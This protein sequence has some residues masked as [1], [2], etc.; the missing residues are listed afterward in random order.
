[1]NGDDISLIFGSAYIIIWLLSSCFSLF[2]CA[3][4]VFCNWKIFVKAGEP[5]WKA[6]IPFYNCYVAYDLFLGN[7]LWFLAIFALCIPIVSLFAL[8]VGVM[9]L[10]RMCQCFGKGVGFIILAIFLSPVALA[11]LA[12]DKSE[13]NPAAA[14]FF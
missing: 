8:F 10:I 3:F 9:Y 12:F 4:V 5:G 1:M 11:I 14:R 2:V 6:I 7:G 13:Y